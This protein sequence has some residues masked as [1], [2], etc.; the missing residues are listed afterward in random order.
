MFCVLGL[1]QLFLIPPLRNFCPGAR[2]RRQLWVSSSRSALEGKR[3]DRHNATLREE[4]LSQKA[5]HRIA[6][7]DM[8]STADDSV[9][10]LT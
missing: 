1:W 6:S 4:K 5:W 7:I 2:T 8:R 3:R 10:T 9:T